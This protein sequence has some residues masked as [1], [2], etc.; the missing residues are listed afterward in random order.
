MNWKRLCVSMIHYVRA[1]KAQGAEPET[2]ALSRRHMLACL[3]VLGAAGMAAPKLL[4]PSLAEASEIEPVAEAA[5]LPGAD[6]SDG[7]LELSSQGRR[8]DRRR[9]PG[10]GRDR[11]RGRGRGRRYGRRDLIR[12]CRRRDFRRR[13]PG[14]CRRVGGWRPRRPGDCINI[15]PVTVCG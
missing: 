15:G 5:D 12:R 11:G 7:S 10:P 3:G 9:R 2:P 8:D 4:A 13:N 14:L 1:P 6:E